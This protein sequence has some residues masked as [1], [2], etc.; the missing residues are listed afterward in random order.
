MRPRRN[1]QG[2]LSLLAIA[3]AL[4]VSA[5]DSAPP[6]PPAAPAKAAAPAVQAKPAPSP[7]PAAPPPPVYAYDPKGRRDP[8]RPLIMPKPPETAA[9]A[10][11]K[12]GLAALDVKD[13]KVA[14][15]VWERRGFFAL[16]EAPTGA[17]YVVRVNDTVGED[18]RVAKITPE[19]ITFEV[20]PPVAAPNAKMRVV[21]LRLRK[22]E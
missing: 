4:V 13:L 17:G 16:I 18:A 7:A 2:S 6:A 9:K 15:I 10:K 19:A 22:E 20:K 5:C 3:L 1:R 14:G 11:P 21:E 8:F 12:T